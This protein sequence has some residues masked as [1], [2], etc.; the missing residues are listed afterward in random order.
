MLE[1]HILFPTQSQRKW[2]V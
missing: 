1:A 2:R